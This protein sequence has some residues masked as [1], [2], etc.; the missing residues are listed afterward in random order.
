MLIQS[1]KG[2]I[3]LLPVDRLGQ[4]WFLHIDLSPNYQFRIKNP[5]LL[6]KE[7]LANH[8]SPLLTDALTPFEFLF[9][10]CVALTSKK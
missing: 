4:E 7:P 3:Y 9:L 2:P 6:L 8:G 5:T 1:I 10:F